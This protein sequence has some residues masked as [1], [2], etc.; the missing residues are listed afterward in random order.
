MAFRKTHQAHF[1]ADQ[2]TVDFVELLDQRIDTRLVQRER[3]DVCYELFFE[4]LVAALL[5]RR[6]RLVL[7]LVLDVLVLQLAQTLVGVGDLVEG[8]DAL[9]LQLRFHRSER[10]RVFEIVLVVI[11]LDRARRAFFIVI[12]LLFPSG[13]ASAEDVAFQLTMP[14]LEEEPFYRGVL[15]FALDQAF[16]GRK[17]L[18][19]VDWGWGAVLSCAL[20]GMTH[21]FGFADGSF[22]FDPM[23]MALTGIP[24]FLAIWMRLRTGSLLLP[25]LLHNFGNSF[26]Y[27]A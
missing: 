10:E 22:S 12:G 27:M 21:A 23:I 24:S 17:R 14:G 15:L 25:V 1:E 3:F 6:E 20:F 13:E 2:T 26:S 11:R 19:G 16:R 9:R 5:A 18:L 8:F 4:L 7:E